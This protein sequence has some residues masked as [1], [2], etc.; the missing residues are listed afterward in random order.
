MSYRYAI[1]LLLVSTTLIGCQPVVK[2][3]QQHT[4]HVTGH[5]VTAVAPNQAHITF[6]IEQEEADL[7]ELKQ[8][9]DQTTT[10][11]LSAL[12]D[13]HVADD[14]IT[15]YNIQA[16]PRYDYVDGTRVQRGFSASRSIKVYL[17]DLSH[18][19]GIINDAF[20]AGAT[21]L[22]QVQFSV[23]EAED[24]YQQLLA[25]AVQH[26]QQKASKIAAA[27][28]RQLGPVVEVHEASYAPPTRQEV[29]LRMAS[30]SVNV[31]LPGK[32]DMQAQVSVTFA[33]EP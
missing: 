17:A 9:I 8:H 7:S 18:Y 30:D 22:N 28:Q 29:M 21:H 4:I 16:G 3:D 25:Q 31:S 10:A 27:S 6:N 1:L 13:H 11:I 26:A 2:S 5:A 32:N 24:I 14:D 33:I 15:S 20:K 12:R 19:D 23:R